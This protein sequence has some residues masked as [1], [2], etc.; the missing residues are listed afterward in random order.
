MTIERRPF[1][2]EGLFEWC[3]D[4]YMGRLYIQCTRCSG[5]AYVMDKL[6]WAY[7]FDGVPEPIAKARRLLLTPFLGRG[8]IRFFARH[9]SCVLAA[10]EED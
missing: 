2:K 9:V 8:A 1:D 10:R 5:W 7:L 6:A 4:T 3:T